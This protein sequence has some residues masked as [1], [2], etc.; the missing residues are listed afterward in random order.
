MTVPAGTCR[1]CQPPRRLALDAL[2]EHFRVMHA[3][4]EPD[5][6]ELDPGDWVEEES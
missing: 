5:E 3:R 1:I 4:P 6:I 2:L